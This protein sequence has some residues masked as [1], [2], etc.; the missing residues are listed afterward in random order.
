MKWKE[1]KKS[2]DLEVLVLREKSR[3][4]V[5]GVGWPST[6]L[7]VRHLRLDRSM[8]KNTNICSSFR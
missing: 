2:W 6:K 1:D 7:E 3:D 4:D 5:T 8:Y